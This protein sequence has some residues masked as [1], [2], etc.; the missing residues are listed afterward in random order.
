[1]NI[2][3]HYRVMNAGRDQLTPPVGCYGVDRSSFADTGIPTTVQCMALLGAVAL[4]YTLSV[5][6]KTDDEAGRK[7]ADAELTAKV[8]KAAILLD[9]DLPAVKLTKA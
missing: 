3:V 7:A 1:M 4:G 6:T 9:R 2:K 8:R 5:W